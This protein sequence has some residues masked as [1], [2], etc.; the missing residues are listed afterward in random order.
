MMAFL[1]LLDDHQLVMP[2]CSHLLAKTK[3]MLLQ[4][5]TRAY[6]ELMVY[7]H[8]QA[9]HRTTVYPRLLDPHLV[10][11]VDLNCQT[12]VFLRHQNH[13]LAHLVC[14]GSK[15]NHRMMACLRHQNHQRA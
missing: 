7:L 2:V 15:L 6:Q 3:R 9:R 14:L 8:H 4:Q 5:A 1:L 11:Q 10:H 12:V 13:H